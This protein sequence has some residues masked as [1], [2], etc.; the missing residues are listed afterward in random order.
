[1]PLVILGVAIWLTHRANIWRLLHGQEP[2][3]DL[4]SK[5]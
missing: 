4:G 5:R 3:I 1:L 2:K